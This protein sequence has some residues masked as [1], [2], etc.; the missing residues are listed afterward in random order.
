MNKRKWWE[1]CKDALAKAGI[2]PNSVSNGMEVDAI[3]QLQ[4]AT[5]AVTFFDGSVSVTYVRDL[6]ANAGRGNLISPTLT[7]KEVFGANPATKAMAQLFGNGVWIRPD[8]FNSIGSAYTVAVVMHE[9]IHNITGL[10][11][12]DIQSHFP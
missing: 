9:L 3:T 12:P 7:V 10:T 5:G 11:D 1:Q 6:F 4:Q 8:Y 2:A